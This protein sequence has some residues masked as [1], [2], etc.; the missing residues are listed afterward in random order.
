MGA[1]EFIRPHL[2]ELAGTRAVRRVT[3]PRSASPAEGSAARHATNQQILVDK[4]YGV[5]PKAG[6]KVADKAR[7]DATLT[8]AKG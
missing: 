4:A 3:R 1:W 8:S 6:G 7:K 2:T 5:T